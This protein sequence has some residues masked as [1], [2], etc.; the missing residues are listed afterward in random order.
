LS[1]GARYAMWPVRDLHW[2]V[3]MRLAALTTVLLFGCAHTQL[4]PQVNVGAEPC[5]PSNEAPVRHQVPASFSLSHDPQ[6]Q[7]VHSQSAAFFSYP[8]EGITAVEMD[9][10]KERWRQRRDGSVLAATEDLVATWETEPGAREGRVVWLDARDGHLVKTSQV[11]LSD[12]GARTAVAVGWIAG[13]EL[14]LEW[15][16]HDWPEDHRWDRRACGSAR[17]ELAG[18][19]LERGGPFPLEGPSASFAPPGYLPLS[20]DTSS[21]PPGTPYVH[22]TWLP[23]AGL[24]A[25]PDVGVSVLVWRLLPAP[26][27]G[28]RPARE[29]RRYDAHGRLL[30]KADAG[31]AQASGPEARAIEYTHVVAGAAHSCALRADGRVF[32][33]GSNRLGQ[34]GQ[35]VPT[36]LRR[37][38]P[39]PPTQVPFLEGVVSLAASA[40]TTCAVTLAG[41]VH[42]WGGEPYSVHWKVGGAFADAVQVALSPSFGCLRRRT[43]TVAC[44]PILEEGVW[45]IPIDGAIGLAMNDHLGCALTSSGTVTCWEPSERRRL[46]WAQK[47]TL[48][49]LVSMSPEPAVGLSASADRTCAVVASGRVTC[50]TFNWGEGDQRWF[51]AP[52]VEVLEVGAHGVA[53]GRAEACALSGQGAHCWA[54]TGAAAAEVRAAT[55]VGLGDAHGCAVVAGK[56]WCWGANGSRQVGVDSSSR[57]P[58]KVQGLGEVSSVDFAKDRGCALRR[59][60]EVWCWKPEQGEAATKVEGVRDAVRLALG[61]AQ[62]CV[63]RRGGQVAC[64]GKTTR[65]T[66]KSE[67]QVPYGDGAHPVPIPGAVGAVEVVVSETQACAQMPRGP[68]RCWSADS[69]ATSVPGTTGLTRLALVGE[70][71]AGVRPDGTD[72]APA[73]LS[74]DRL[75]A[76]DALDPALVC[77]LSRTGEAQCYQPLDGR[78]PPRPLGPALQV[79]PGETTCLVRPGGLVECLGANESGQLGDGTRRRRDLPGPVPGVPSVSAVATSRWQTCAV[80]TTGQLWCWGG[81]PARD[82]EPRP[83]LVEELP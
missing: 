23:A 58:A 56:V 67:E 63:V 62:A 55:S 21:D 3:P 31:T 24:E 57:L 7:L 15:A 42:C 26:V 25:R 82:V 13:G 29:L 19:T 71:L 1:F 69:A 40:N 43:G 30:W 17:L 45:N 28:A 36:V 60:G 61:A 2:S 27:A 83:V 77:H 37:D 32:C 22:T 74:D 9:T 72:T 76:T 64:W 16:A 53:V 12:F 8:G 11:R 41:E 52:K 44:W 65:L 5:G 70:T 18:E 35:S 50:W 33:W 4:A 38:D 6:L 46:D 48:R 54:W 39:W 79:A 66:H 68:A 81:N 20:F 75:D 47:V 80:A 59:D 49:P 78:T 10:G 14:V 51:V 34:V 73:Q